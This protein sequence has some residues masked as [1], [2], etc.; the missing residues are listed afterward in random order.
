[1]SRLAPVGLLV[2]VLSLAV[3]G[4]GG[5]DGSGSAQLWVTRDRGRTVLLRTTVPAGETAMQ[6]LDR[7]VDL[8]TRYGG[9][10]VQSIDGLGGSLAARRDWFWFLNG[11]EADRSAA[12][13][14]LAD[15]DVEWW[16]FRA[17]A[18]RMRQPA[19]VGAFPQPFVGG[20][21]AAVVVGAGETARKLAR[22]VHGRVAATAPPGA[23][24]L[25][26][27]PGQ[28]FTASRSS[29]GGVV[30]TLGANDAPRLA[31]DPSLAR[32]RFQGLP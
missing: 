16:D 1:M 25:R 2:L 23:N 8:E 30:F 9:R 5:G 7:A 19:V 13:V 26:I 6:A 14:R 4:C 12:E 11:L 31:A 18:G 22:I 15:G 10:F 21:R 17:W 20:G 27:V 32:F 3:A 28:G 24:V 29:G